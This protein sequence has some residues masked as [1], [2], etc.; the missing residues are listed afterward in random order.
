MYDDKKK[1]DAWM[2]ATGIRVEKE[3]LAEQKKK[4]FSN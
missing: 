2:D 4:N 3:I 1:M